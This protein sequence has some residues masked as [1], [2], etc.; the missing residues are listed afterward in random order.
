MAYTSG[1]S[2]AR[3]ITSNP[4]IVPVGQG[5]QGAGLTGLSESLVRAGEVKE[6]RRI[7]AKAEKMNAEAAEVFRGGN[8]EDIADF[9]IRNPEFSQALIMQSQ[10]RDKETLDNYTDSSFGILDIVESTPKEDWGNEDI[11]SQVADNIQRR[12]AF[13][14]S[15]GQKPEDMGFTLGFMQKFIDDPEDAIQQLKNEMASVA[16]D[17]YIKR[18]EALSD[19]AN[20]LGEMS[21]D[22]N[23][24]MMEKAKGTKEAQGSYPEWKQ[25]IT[26]IIDEGNKDKMRWQAIKLQTEILKLNQ[27]MRNEDKESQLG[28]QKRIRLGK[29]TLRNVD[30][31]MVEIDQALGLSKKFGTTGF[32]G[33]LLSRVKGTS[34]F[35]LKKVI[36][37]ID[38]GIAFETLRQM[39]EASPT[40]GALGQVSNFEIDLLKAT[41]ASTHA[42]MGAERLAKNL[43]KIQR[44][45]NNWSKMVSQE[46]GEAEAEKLLHKNYDEYAK[47]DTFKAVANG[48]TLQEYMDREEPAKRVGRDGEKVPKQKETPTRVPNPPKP[49]DPSTA[50]AVPITL[51]PDEVA[52]LS[53]PEYLEYLRALSNEDK[54]D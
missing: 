29:Q 21:R 32:L 7:E 46:I 36:N 53:K 39:R 6:R 5:L 1:S 9:A 2:M 51:T 37:T 52:E 23:V 4:F 31:V 19:P 30:N 50:N 33:D 42:G 11:I 3:N 41:I 12:Q 44:H 38:A 24:Y 22:Y 28:I 35:E 54:K 40:G 10:I 15:K 20:A 43:E 27:F 48:E 17:R 45:Y 8:D 26:N 13:L 47:T 18:S 14:E 25:H 34:A 16:P 49:D